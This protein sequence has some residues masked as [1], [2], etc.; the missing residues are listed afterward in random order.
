[1]MVFRQIGKCRDNMIGR[2][3]P[4]VVDASSDGQFDD[5]QGAQV[6]RHAAVTLVVCVLNFSVLGFEKQL[7]CIAAFAGVDAVAVRVVQKLLLDGARC[8]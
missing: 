6:R 8:E 2:Q 5:H 7:H 4:G 1:M 3:P